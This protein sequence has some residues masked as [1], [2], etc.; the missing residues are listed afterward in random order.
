MKP[1]SAIYYIKE[2]KKRS[3]ISIFMLFLTTLIFLAGNYVESVYYFWDRYMDYSDK[4][5]VVKSLSTDENFE[6]FNSFYN[7]LKSDENLIVQQRTGWGHIGLPWD[8]TLGFEM[9][10]ASMVFGSVDDMKEA[11]Q[12]L[13]IEC[14]YSELKDYSVVMS[15]TFAKHYGLSKGDI[16]DASVYKGINGRYTLDAIIDD[17]SFVLF[18]VIPCEETVVRLNV[19]SPTMSGQELR[20]YIAAVQGDRKAQIDE[21]MRDNINGQ[22]VPFKIIFST[23]IVLLSL[24]LSIIVNSVITGQYIRRVYEF[25]VYRAIGISKAGIVKKCAAEILTMNILSTVLGAGLI[26][27][28]TFMI[29]ELYYIPNGKF[30]P[31]ISKMGIY[32]FILSNI[33]VVIPT[34][35]L[36]GREMCRAD[37]TEF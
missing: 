8:C 7:D 25:G 21:P 14:D 26:I 11:F 6:D 16:I 23:G 10:T 29:N 4:V 22:F 3:F 37:V 24:M 12:H 28:F 31:Y 19:M 34:I 33:L 13:G 1:F 36:K 27:F 20:D 17:E 2:N 18:Y 35:L 30:L 5:C 15:E 9:G 32:G